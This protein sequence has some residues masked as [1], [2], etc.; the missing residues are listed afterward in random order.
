MDLLQE[1]EFANVEIPE[2]SAISLAFAFFPPLFE[3]FLFVILLFASKDRHCTVQFIFN[4]SPKCFAV[5]S[6][7]KLLP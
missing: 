6:V 4:A 7:N 2:S 5:V 1:I 3:R